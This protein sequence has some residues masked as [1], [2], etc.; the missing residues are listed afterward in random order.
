MQWEALPT[1]GVDQTYDTVYSGEIFGPNT[2]RG[3]IWDALDKNP[4][5]VV[6]WIYDM[7]GD[8]YGYG[9]GYKN[10]YT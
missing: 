7:L 2:T 3:E 6:E 5:R 4:A 9:Y 10:K 8:E 1:V